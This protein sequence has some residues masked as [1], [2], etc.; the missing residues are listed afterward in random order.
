MEPTTSSD[1]AQPTGPAGGGCPFPHHALSPATAEPAPA[2]C[3][4]TSP[5]SEADTRMRRFLRIPE[6]PRASA[7]AAEGAF[8]KSVLVSAVRCLFTYLVLPL[9]G[10][11]LGLS[12]TVGPT[13]GLIVGAVSIVAIT[14][15]IRRFFRADHRWR[16]RY[17]GIGGGIIVLLLV[18][19]V[20]DVADLAG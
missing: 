4:F 8:S 17:T 16:W 3:P 10:P 7:A 12:G 1:V 13:L 2:T 14:A 9:L 11:V 20:I 19:A 15:S 5:R 6:G 18:Q